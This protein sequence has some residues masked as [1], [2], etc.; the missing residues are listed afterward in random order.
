[1][2]GVGLMEF[3]GVGVGDG[4]GLLKLPGVGIGVRVGL[5][6]LLSVGIEHCS[7]RVLCPVL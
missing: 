1:M 4:V 7:Y 2:V 3:S 5:M 6:K